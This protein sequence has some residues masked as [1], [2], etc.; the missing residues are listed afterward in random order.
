MPLI[1]A[2]K[3][4]CSSE[5]MG[6]SSETGVLEKLQRHPHPNIVSVYMTRSS[7]YTTVFIFFLSLKSDK[8]D[9]CYFEQHLGLLA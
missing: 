3:I 4:L 9:L 6:E 2:V 5:V 8:M 1:I 7:D